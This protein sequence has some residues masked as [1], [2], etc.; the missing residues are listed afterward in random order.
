MKYL[1]IFTQKYRMPQWLANN[2]LSA[3]NR[4]ETVACLLADG[5]MKGDIK[6]FVQ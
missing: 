6:P 1:E 3:R 2:I 4:K 5:L